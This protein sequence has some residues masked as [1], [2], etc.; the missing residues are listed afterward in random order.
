[1]PEV[2]KFPAGEGS[3]LLSLADA[4]SIKVNIVLGASM[5]RPR[6]FSGINGCNDSTIVAVNKDDRVEDDQRDRVLLPV[7]WTAVPIVFRTIGTVV[8]PYGCRP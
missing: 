5:P 7:L 8:V 3:K 2:P 6:G 1:M 4:Q